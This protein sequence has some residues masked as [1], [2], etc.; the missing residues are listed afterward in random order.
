MKPIDSKSK[1]GKKL[2]KLRKDLG[3]TQ[4]EL[5]ER[6]G[7]DKQQISRYERG[8]NEP[9][10]ETL[11]RIVDYTGI[12]SGYFISRDIS[13]PYGHYTVEQKKYIDDLIE[14]LESGN[15]VM[16]DAL[17]ANIKAFLKAVRMGKKQN[18]DKGGD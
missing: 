11:N 13:T 5:G 15:E 12:D 4:V 16:A 9:R 17:K 18:E 14:V 3:L 10:I 2:R 8:M 7:I 1:I 6:V